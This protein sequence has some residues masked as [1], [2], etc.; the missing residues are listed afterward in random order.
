MNRVGGGVVLD[1]AR[2]GMA[3]AGIRA[4]ATWGGAAGTIPPFGVAGTSAP[5]ESCSNF[6][7]NLIRD[8]VIG[9]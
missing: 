5:S 3:A 7:R 9:P 2:H 8:V 6:W 4:V 1:L